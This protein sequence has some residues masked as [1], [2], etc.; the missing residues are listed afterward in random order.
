[1]QI[2]FFEE[3]PTVENLEKLSLLE[4]PCTVYLAA[5]SVDEFRQLT[6]PWRE[7]APHISWS[8]WPLLPDSYWI[9]P[10]SFPSELRQ[11][12]EDLQRPHEEG[13]EI[14]LD[15]EL[16][17]RAPRLFWKNA[18]HFL[19]NRRHIRG[20]FEDASRHHI[21]I[22]TAEYPLFGSFFQGLLNQLGLA[23]DAHTQHHTILM[24]Y[25]SIIPTFL[26]KLSQRSLLHYCKHTQHPVKVGLGT[27]ATG[28]FG[29]EPILTPS[30]L[31]ADLQFLQTHGI[32][33]AVIFRL[34]GLDDEYMDVIRSFQTHS[35]HTK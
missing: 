10:F 6:A 3:F 9:S 29:N 5:H 24:F 4:S 15:L 27:I 23:Y 32:H 11:L 14:L 19:R 2:D 12:V 16:P 30:S 25:T 20:V 31:R 8:F 26:H 34:G 35:A 28:I 21:Q 13:L 7:K 33:Q 17:L 22:A 18:R 1:M